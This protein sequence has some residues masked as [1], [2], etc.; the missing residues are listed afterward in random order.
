V[1]DKEIPHHAGAEWPS[2]LVNTPLRPMV[3]RQ[4]E[5]VKSAK[6]HEVTGYTF[7]LN[8]MKRPRLVR[9]D[10]GRL[11]LSAT[12]WLYKTGE[13]KGIVM[14][15]EDQGRSWSPPREIRTWQDVPGHSWSGRLVGLGQSLLSLPLEYADVDAQ[16]GFRG[17][18]R[19][20]HHDHVSV[21]LRQ[22]LWE[23]LPFPSAQH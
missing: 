8:S 19:R 13:E 1:L 4:G 9:M 14:T 5:D 10:N 22:F 17:I 11:V 23:S 16:P 15:L 6:Y 2:D 18:V 21:P 12:S 7:L 3:I 20:S